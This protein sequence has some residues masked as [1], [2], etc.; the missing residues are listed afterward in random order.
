[1]SYIS[2]FTSMLRLNCWR[3]RI[4]WTP[5][6]PCQLS[7]WIVQY[8]WN[9]PGPVSHNITHDFSPHCKDRNRKLEFGNITHMWSLYTEYLDE[10]DRVIHY[11]P[12]EWNHPASAPVLPHRWN[13]RSIAIET[14]WNYMKDLWTPDKVYG[15]SSLLYSPHQP[16]HR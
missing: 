14:H 10:N 7:I 3:S 2:P 11:S 5:V 12:I 15:R 16:F 8:A 13:S 9:L 4:S 6:N 1:M